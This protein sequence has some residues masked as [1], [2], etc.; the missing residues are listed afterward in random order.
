MYINNYHVQGRNEDFLRGGEFRLFEKSLRSSTPEN[1]KKELIWC[2]LA[3]IWW[4]FFVKWWTG[5]LV[6]FGQ[7]FPTNPDID[8][9]ILHFKI[10]ISQ[11][12]AL[13]V[14]FAVLLWRKGICK[15]TSHKFNLKDLKTVYKQHLYQIM[16]KGQREIGL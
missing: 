4:A 2:V 10:R 6:K 15:R 11:C 3:N 7:L 1:L 9:Y 13:L 5:N 16:M 8:I 14:N 12:L